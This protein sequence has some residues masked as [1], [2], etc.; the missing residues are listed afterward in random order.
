MVFGKRGPAVSGKLGIKPL[1]PKRTRTAGADNA[2]GTPRPGDDI[3]GLCRT[4]DWLR[5]EDNLALAGR[6][7]C[8]NRSGGE[9][10][11][12]RWAGPYGAAGVAGGKRAALRAVEAATPA[13]L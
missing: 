12:R 13:Q 7:T 11:A 2:S 6:A 3:R 9:R 5:A 8:A 4:P 10:S 1:N